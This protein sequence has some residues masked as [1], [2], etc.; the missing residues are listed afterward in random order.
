VELEFLYELC[1][2]ETDQWR[3]G[4]LEAARDLRRDADIFLRAHPARW[5]GRFAA[6]VHRQS[7]HVLYHGL[8]DLL[9]AHLA[10]DLGEDF[11]QARLPWASAPR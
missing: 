2:R 8:A 10:I 5:F 7:R 1:R 6:A 9:T 4:D 3:A 11:D